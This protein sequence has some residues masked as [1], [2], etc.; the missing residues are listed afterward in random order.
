MQGIAMQELSVRINR[1]LDGDALDDTLSST[2]N[3]LFC[4]E[5]LRGNASV[6]N[7]RRLLI[8]QKPVP[9]IRHHIRY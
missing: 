6:L 8:L 2:T 4:E 3:M 5:G 7:K 1:S 9:G